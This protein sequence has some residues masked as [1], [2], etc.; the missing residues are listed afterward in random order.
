[1]EQQIKIAGQTINY[2]KKGNGPQTILCF[3]G[4][5]GTIW[6]DFTPQIEELDT[7]KFT[8]VVWDPPGYG[9]SRPPQRTFTNDF[10]IKDADMAAKLMKELHIDKYS[11]LG[12]SD[13]GNSSMILSS[14]YPN[15]V[16]NLVIWGSNSKILPDDITACE[17]IRDINSWSEK[18]KRPFIKMYGDEFQ[19]LINNWLD[20][21]HNIAKEGGNICHDMLPSIKCPTLI[22]HGNKD[23]M[24]A[25][26]HPDI[27]LKN[28]KNSK[29]HRFP[30][31]KHN[32]HLRY[33]QEFNAVVSRFIEEHK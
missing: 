14:M 29:I 25:E 20:A 6:T 8:V 27:L 16:D 10:Y 3:P 9:K 12:W 5:F 19:T 28:I 2:L 1:M 31:G 30:E 22:L 23:A 15:C 24:I 7:K 4:A 26:E 33:S 17:K 11:L 13:G 21:L 32:I 18:M